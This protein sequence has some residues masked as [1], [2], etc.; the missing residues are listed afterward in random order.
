MEVH[1]ERGHRS[2]M[3]PARRATMA[4]VD[5]RVAELVLR[6]VEQVPRGRVVA[7]GD[8]AGLVGIGP[9]QVGSIMRTYGSGVTWWRVTSS[10]G[11]LPQ[12]LHEE[13]RVRWLEEG[14][15][16]KPNGLGCRIHEY[17]CDLRA[18]ARSWDQATADLRGSPDD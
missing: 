13:A 9:R 11:D 18:L 8:L 12:H 1:G 15:A 6:A 17:R 16:W 3:P 10:S 14:I 2:M 7:Y 4:G 5:E